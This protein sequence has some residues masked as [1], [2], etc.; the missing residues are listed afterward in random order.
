[1]N[2][3]SVITEGKNGLVVEVADPD[4]V[5]HNLD[6]APRVQIALTDA[7]VRLGCPRAEILT[8]RKTR[9]SCSQVKVR[10]PPMADVSKQACSCDQD[11]AIVAPGARKNAPAT[12]QNLR[13]EVLVVMLVGLTASRHRGSS[14]EN[15][16]PTDQITDLRRHDRPTGP[17]ICRCMRGESWS[18]RNP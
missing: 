13:A 11:R 16:G 3:C 14:R 4:V 6:A 12:G 5:V 1:M 15:H 10:E 18:T 17:L 8:Q 2:A 7:P 9:G